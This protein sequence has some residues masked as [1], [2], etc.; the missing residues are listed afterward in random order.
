[1]EEVFLEMTVSRMVFKPGFVSLLLLVST[2]G[3][4]LGFLRRARRLRSPP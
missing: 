4:F 3:S 1:M 2:H